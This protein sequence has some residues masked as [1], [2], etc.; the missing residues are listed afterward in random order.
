MRRTIAIPLTALAAAVIMVVAFLWVGPGLGAFAG[1]ASA[2]P[3]LYDESLVVSMYDQVAPAVVQVKTGT[4]G[5][6]SGFLI[7]AEGHIVTNNHVLASAETVRVVLDGGQTVEASVVG[8]S[9]AHDLALLKVDS[10]AVSGIQPLVLGDSDDLDPGQMAIALGN[11]YGLD[12]TVTLGIIS[13]LGRSLPSSL[14]RPIA[15]VIQTDAAINP[16]NSGGPLLNSSGEVVGIN[17]AI[18]T[19]TLGGNA[20]IGFAVPVNMLKELLP[21]LKEGGVVQ[22]AY[23]G[24]RG[25]SVDETLAERLQLSETL[26]VYVVEVSPNGPTEEAG[27][28][29]AGT[30]RWGRPTTGG[31]IIT[32]VDGQP[33]SSVADIAG[34]LNG[35]HEG[36]IVTLTVVRNG[37]TIFVPVT[38]DSWPEQDDSP[39]RVLPPGIPDW[40]EI[41]P[42]VPKGPFHEQEEGEEGD[43]WRRFREFRER[44]PWEEMFPLR[45]GR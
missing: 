13:G 40:P 17:T 14:D 11:P 43:P 29:A 10:G 42:D 8:R 4:Q 1:N 44:F 5:L 19:G 38:L 28:L 3:V 25:Q 9:P 30:D 35:K 34:Y 6:G 22:P 45:P 33:V 31:D 2:A 26:G 32:A 7:D 24:I 23:L 41:L 39:G 16:G 37:S 27:L 18:E 15:D 12:D 20:G 21:H 36:D